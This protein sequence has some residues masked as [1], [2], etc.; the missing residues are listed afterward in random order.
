MRLRVIARIRRHQVR[1]A[2]QPAL[3][4]FHR[5]GQQSAIARSFVEHLIVRDDLALRFRQLHQLAEFGRLAGLAL[6]ND[7]AV[8]L[9]QAHDLFRGLRV[10]PKDARLGLLHHLP[11]PL[12][13][14]CQIFTQ[15]PYSGLPTCRRLTQYAFGVVQDLPCQSQQ[16]AI[17]LPALRHPRFAL[18]AAGVRNRSH[19]LVHAASPVADTAL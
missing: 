7:F 9:K 4:F 5:L 19:T 8:R 12:R 14:P 2:P 3:L 10:V 16:T 17:V 6:P 1:H 13:H 15:G 18:I 11:N